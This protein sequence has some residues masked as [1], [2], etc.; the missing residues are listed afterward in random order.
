MC[1]YPMKALIVYLHFF[2]KLWSNPI[3]KANL[4][5]QFHL[6][7]TRPWATIGKLVTYTTY[8]RVVIC[9]LSTELICVSPYFW[10]LNLLKT[11]LYFLYDSK[12]AFL[13]LVINYIQV[14]WR[15][16][17]EYSQQSLSSCRHIFV[18]RLWWHCSQ[19]ILWQRHLPYLWNYGET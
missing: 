15:G 11:R 9:I 7:G 6:L 13:W 17:R 2:I 3:T 12:H 8:R 10:L 1:T 18:R 4:W 14:S 19:H 16:I 5:I